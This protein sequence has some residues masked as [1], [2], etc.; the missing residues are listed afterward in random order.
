MLDLLYHSWPGAPCVRAELHQWADPGAIAGSALP[1]WDAAG[2]RG[3]GRLAA[4]M[5]S[6]EKGT[7]R[8]DQVLAARDGQYKV[9][10]IRAR[11]P[12]GPSTI[13]CDGQRRWKA[14]P[15]RLVVGPAA[16]LRSDVT[17]M[18][19]SAWLLGAGCPE[20]SR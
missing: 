8:A 3:A 18:I 6:F 11:R 19:D 2:V 7:Y 4:A 20:G 1:G 16:P 14:Y 15:G 10:T 9:Q 13:A 12:R 17:R 5:A